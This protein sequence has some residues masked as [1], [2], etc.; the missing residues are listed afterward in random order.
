MYLFIGCNG[1]VAAISPDDGREIWR[2]S[3]GRGFLSTTNCQD[4]CVL[5]DGDRVLAGSH[6]YLYALDAETGEILWENE[7]KGMGYN[8]VTLAM[9]GKSVQYVSQ[10]SRSSD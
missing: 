9:A 8:D 5:E 3:L 4:V 7:L 10:R 1:F 6:G 2:T